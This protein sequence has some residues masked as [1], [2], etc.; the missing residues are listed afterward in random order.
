MQNS[1]SNKKIKNLHINATLNLIRKGIVLF[2]PLITFPYISRVLDVENVGRFNYY[3]SIINYF[4]LLSALGIPLYAANYGAKIRDNKKE[5]EHFISEVLSINVL[6]TL[7]S[8]IIFLIFIIWNKEIYSDFSLM[9]ILSIMIVGTTI[10]M[11]WFFVIYEDYLYIT[12]RVICIQLISFILIFL[13]VK[14]K[15]SLPSYGWI[16]VFSQVGAAPVNLYLIKK[17][18]KLSLS[19]EFEKIKKHILPIMTIFALNV[20]SQIYI[21]ADMTMLGVIKGD[22]YTGLYSVSNKVY[23]VLKS[24]MAALYE[25]ALPNLSNKIAV[26][27]MESYKVEIN[28]LLNNILVFLVPV[29][30]GVVIVADDIIYV[31]GG[32]NYQ[33]AEGS[34]KVL[35]VSLLFAVLSGVFMYAVLLPLGQEKITM[36]AMIVSAVI[37]VGLNFIFIPKYHIMGASFTTAI[38]ECIVFL[39]QC[40]YVSKY[41][42]IR[43]DYKNIMQIILGCFMIAVICYSVNWFSMPF[44]ISFLCKVIF[45]GLVYFLVLLKL[46]NT[47]VRTIYEFIIKRNPWFDLRKK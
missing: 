18:I 46:R 36:Y 47:Y 1:F 13:L 22:Y 37:N 31:V 10:G 30:C 20:S 5:C 44:A 33:Q 11:D 4:M 12:I 41:K 28:T 6:S 25:A 39:W 23:K 3:L 29:M 14:D 21:N 16:Y 2:F 19:F 9:L 17:N 34:L 27:G 45:S 43:F 38:S 7:L 32:N 24:L 35:G 42:I 40:V 26:E 15:S 8:Y